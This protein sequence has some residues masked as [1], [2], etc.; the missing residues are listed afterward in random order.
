MEIDRVERA[1]AAAGF[2]ALGAF[3][4]TKDDGVLPLDGTTVVATLVLIG[5]AGPAMWHRFE[6]ERD[7]GTD[8]MDTWSRQTIGAVASA[9]GGGAYF[10]F[11]K[12]YLPF[13]RWA[14]RAG[15]YQPSPLGMFIHPDFGLWH[16]YRGA[17]GFATRL[18]LAPEDPVPRTAPCASCVDKPC[19]STCPVGAFSNQG[20]DVPACVAHLQTD[21]G[22]DCMELG[23]RARRACPVGQPFHYAPA[24]A[25][26]H[27]QAFLRAHMCDNG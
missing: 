12:P 20:Y 10:P 6:A 13:Q 3:H 27:M 19:L 7:G 25:H 5:N 17:L 2:T 22:R 15:A 4:P 9:L 14:R 11:D 18:D 8:P 21:A 16:A 26:F 1:I 23:C 24:Q